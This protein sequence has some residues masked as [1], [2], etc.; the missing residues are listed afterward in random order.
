FTEAYHVMYSGGADQLALSMGWGALVSLTPGEPVPEVDGEEAFQYL[1]Q[2][3]WDQAVKRDV[4][5]LRDWIAHP[6]RDEYWKLR[7]IDGN[8]MD[9]TVPILN[10]GGWYDI[11]AKETLEQINRVRHESRDFHNRRNQFV[12][13][14]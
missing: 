10:I 6:A 14:G 12:I 8:F 4:F 2:Q 3:T 7:G 1:P 11:F 13:M 5:Y 9:V